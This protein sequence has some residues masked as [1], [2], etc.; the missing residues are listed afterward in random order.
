M[1]RKCSTVQYSSWKK[2]LVYCTVQHFWN[3]DLLHF[4]NIDL[5]VN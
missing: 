2:K 4:R 5:Y 3:I 1:F